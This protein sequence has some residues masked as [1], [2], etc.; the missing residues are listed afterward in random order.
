MFSA[1][2]ALGTRRLGIDVPEAFEPLE[3]G[4]VTFGE[5][6]LPDSIC[7]GVVNES[8]TGAGTPAA[9]NT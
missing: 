2:C 1:G 4:P 5:P 3:I 7:T 9:A 8:V 6:R